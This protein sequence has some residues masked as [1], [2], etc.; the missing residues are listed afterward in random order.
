M[1]YHI[2]TE[3]NLLRIE[4]F[5]E[6]SPRD[7]KTLADTLQEIDQRLAVTPVR[8]A[9]LRNVSGQKLTFADMY[10]FVKRRQLQ[11]FN[12]PVKTALVATHPASKGF[13]RMFQTLNDHP[14]VE[15]QIFSTMEAAEEWLAS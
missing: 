7:L 12:N 15:V 1:P 14:Q 11:V 13:A 10:T 4:F 9:D 3:A 6:F 2:T 8:L 5:D